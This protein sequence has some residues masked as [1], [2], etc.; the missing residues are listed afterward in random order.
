MLHLSHAHLRSKHFAECDFL[1]F[2]VEYKKMGF[3][4]KQNL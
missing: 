4:S 1:I 3:A 2:M